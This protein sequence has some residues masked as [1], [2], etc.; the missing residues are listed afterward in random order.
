[1]KDLVGA[2]RFA[3]IVVDVAE[4]HKRLE[5]CASSLAVTT[6]RPA[7]RWRIAHNASAQ[8]AL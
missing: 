8:G 4:T 1:M 2:H 3:F 7:F 6:D 5:S